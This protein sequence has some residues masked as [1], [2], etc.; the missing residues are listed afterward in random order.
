MFLLHP[1]HWATHQRPHGPVEMRYQT[2]VGVTAK[3]LPRKLYACRGYPTRAG[4]GYLGVGRG[5]GK[6]FLGKIKIQLSLEG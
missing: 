2:N 6:P 5:F 4:I 1:G 3:G